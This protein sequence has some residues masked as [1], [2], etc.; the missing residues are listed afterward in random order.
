MDSVNADVIKG[1]LRGRRWGDGSPGHLL[2][3]IPAYTGVPFVE[4]DLL[5]AD[6]GHPGSAAVIGSGFFFALDGGKG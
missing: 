6:R 4:V 2:R 1:A 3:A 5:E